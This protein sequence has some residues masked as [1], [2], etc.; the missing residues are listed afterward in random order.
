MTDDDR[1]MHP[2]HF[3]TD[4]MD[5]RI[6]IGIN[7]KIRIRVRDHF[8]L[9]FGVGAGLRSLSAFVIAVIIVIIILKKSCQCQV[10]R[11]SYITLIRLRYLLQT[12]FRHRP[13]SIP[14]IHDL[15]LI[16]INNC[17]RLTHD[18]SQ[19]SAVGQWYSVVYKWRYIIFSTVYSWAAQ[20]HSINA[21]THVVC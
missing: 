20:R 4:P 13:S 2:Q 3:G 14:R 9:I 15:I 1:I 8:F 17:W 7:P 19:L 6:R 18:A 16:D 10:K 11:R 21:V 12:K 5:I